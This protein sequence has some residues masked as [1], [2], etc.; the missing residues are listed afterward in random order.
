M[1]TSRGEINPRKPLGSP[2]LF[3]LGDQGGDR[4]HLRATGKPAVRTRWET[5]RVT[6]RGVWRCGDCVAGPKGNPFQEPS[7]KPFLG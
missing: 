7:G 2:R 6:S 1:A 4:M 5:L 3:G